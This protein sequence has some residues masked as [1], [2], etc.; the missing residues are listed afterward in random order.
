MLGLSSVYSYLTVGDLW[1]AD[2][3]F[4]AGEV[5]SE[6]CKC[7]KFL[8]MHHMVSVQEDLCY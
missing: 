3:C 7:Q 4:W 6:S 8:F 1:E 5:K 2:F